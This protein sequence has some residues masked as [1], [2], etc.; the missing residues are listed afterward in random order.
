MT[1]ILPVRRIAK[2]GMS[3]TAR[4][5][6]KIIRVALIS[7]VG[8]FSI[9]ASA[10]E[11]APTRVG[12]E[13]S[14]KPL[15]FVRD[16][17]ELDG[18]AVELVRAV[19]HEKGL[20][21]Q[22][23][24]GPW[25]DILGRFQNGEI[26]MIANVA[27][28]KERDA[29]IDFAVPHLTMA[30]AI[31]V[32]RGDKTIR[33]L[34]DLAT[35][36]IAVQPDSFSQAYLRSRGYA[37]NFVFVKSLHDALHTL[38]EG[39][40]DAV[41][42]IRIVG[43][44]IVR[45]HGLKNVAVSDI[46]LK[47]FSLQLHMGVH[48]GDADRLAL[49]NDG[50]ARIR[51]NG[52]YDQIY[53]K[54]LGPLEPRRLRL[55]D[56]RPVV[57]PVLITT[58]AII[59]ALWWQRRLL[60]RLADK[61]ARLRESE[62]RLHRVLEGTE[63]GFWD[64]DM[65]TGRIER[66]ARWASMLGYTLAE[67]EP[68]RAAGAALVHP[69]DLALYDA[70]QERLKTHAMERCDIE[71]R[72]R[73]KSGEWRWILD[74][75]KVVAWT[76]DGRP[77]RMS[78]THTDIT[79][80]K[81]TEAALME[82]Q[83]LLKR[84]AQLLRRTQAAAN[85]GGWETDLAT[86]R[87]YWTPETYR[88]HDT[89]PEEFFPT[90]ESIFSFYVPESHARLKAAV[91]AVTRDGTPYS[92]ELEII[93][94]R[95]RQAYVHTS[96]VAEK[97]NGRVVKLYGSFRDI[98][99]DRA[100]EHE[101]EQ[102]RLKMLESQKLESLGVLAGG[103]AHDFNNLLTVILAN[104][105]FMRGTGTGNNEHLVHIETAAH[106]AGDLCRQMLA[107][108]GKGAF[109]VEPLDVSV[110]VQDTAQ[111][112]NVS[113]SKKAR[114]RLALAPSLPFVDADA[115]QL[116]QVVMNLVINASEALGDACGEILIATRIERPESRTDIV[117]HT[118]DLPPGECVCLE[119]ADTGHGMSGETLARI[120]DPFFTTKFTGRGL[121]LAAVLGIVRAHHGALTVET[122]PEQGTTFRLYL[123]ASSRVAVPRTAPAPVPSSAPLARQQGSGTL[124]I[125][126]DEPFVLEATSAV[127][128]HRGYETVLATDGNDA[129]GRFR[130]NPDRFCA[131]LLDLTM[132]GLGGAEALRAIRS[133]NATVPAL[134][135]SGF[136]EQ[137]VFDRVRGLGRVSI[138][139][140][141]FTQE[142][143]LSRVAEI[144]KGR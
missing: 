58:A 67:I 117:S 47:D 17:G 84:S 76:A 10:A 49:L 78:G 44:H 73:T 53:E 95:H 34:T 124:L 62:E 18:F 127:L 28:T 110:L 64:W 61:A 29:F 88:I 45:T 38:D 59:G 109:L 69:E 56:L 72:M 12:F 6:F 57:L 128:R 79:E 30:G 42:A 126:D 55:S 65:E 21:L 131:V 98:T 137:D 97:E 140:K 142:V 138:V 139:R 2:T 141:P 20:T 106:R 40:C 108:A 9:I 60:R 26:D 130:E 120:F 63:D 96:G 102:L 122:A 16:D 24:A 91:E 66:S 121:G 135:M 119:I 133:V 19:A 81:R 43:T 100:A 41:L 80:R 15:S 90:R 125:A 136:S 11:N 134:V 31:F 113:I 107:Y 35:R 99:A 33:S 13:I 103:I 129:V 83:A 50:L 71:Y 3:K 4:R 143:L 39:K 74:R 92:L 101:R 1:P 89:T 86:G 14:A 46:D 54:W 85:I 82:S 70:W 93:T 27:Y 115:S 51:D 77:K 87:V 5:R 116:R 105:S 114:I 37:Q 112:I 22:T 36:R 8:F 75:G 94:A 118:F 111:L 144:V 7:I 48:A 123:P 25:A 52:I 132:P 32:R 23:V 68:T 104:A